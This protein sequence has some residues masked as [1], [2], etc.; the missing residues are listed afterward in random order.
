[1]EGAAAS[2]ADLL[3]W[4]PA[5]AAREVRAFLDDQET[6]FRAGPVKSNPEPTV[7]TGQVGEKETWHLHTH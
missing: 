7:E 3:K 4:S 1:V 5:Q 2:V 6:V